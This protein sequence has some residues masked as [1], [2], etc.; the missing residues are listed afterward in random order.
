M[1]QK[2]CRKSSQPNQHTR[3][4]KSPHSNERRTS[5]VQSPSCMTRGSMLF[6]SRMFHGGRHNR[7]N[8]WATFRKHMAQFCHKTLFDISFRVNLIV[9]SANFSKKFK[10]EVQR[11]TNLKTT[12]KP[13]TQVSNFLFKLYTQNKTELRFKLYKAGACLLEKAICRIIF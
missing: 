7:S 4:R 6:S 1:S 10:F 12:F 8:R 13:K 9:K 3:S 2:F 5:K 11:G